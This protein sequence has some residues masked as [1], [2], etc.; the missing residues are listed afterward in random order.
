M[1]QDWNREITDVVAI[2]RTAV[3]SVNTLSAILALA[4]SVDCESIEVKGALQSRECLIRPCLAMVDLLPIFCMNFRACCRFPNQ[5]N[6]NYVG[7]LPRK[8]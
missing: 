8:G 6:V 7:D 2:I 4:T 3:N 5:L 1:A